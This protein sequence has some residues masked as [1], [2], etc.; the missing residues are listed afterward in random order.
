AVMNIG[1]V[2]EQYA[3]PEEILR[4]PATAFV[5]DF[6]GAE[7]GLKRLALITVADIKTEEGPVVP[8]TSAAEEARAVIDRFGLGWATGVDEDG[9]LVG[10][11]E[12]EAREG[13]QRGDEVEPRRFGAYV[14]R[15]SSL[16]EALDSIVTS[17]TNVAV[18]AD[19]GDRYVGILTVER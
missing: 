2:I 11:V 3:P 12:E 7:R 5:V 9:R 14:T 6:V 4:D 15:A 16:R 17:R 13:K 19:D 1:G 8:R 10:W 18:V